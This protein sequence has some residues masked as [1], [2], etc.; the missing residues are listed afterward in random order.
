MRARMC[1]RTVWESWRVRQVAVRRVRLMQHRS[2]RVRPKAHQHSVVRLIAQVSKGQVGRP[3]FGASVQHLEHGARKQCALGVR[4]T[5][6]DLADRT[7]A[8]QERSSRRLI[9]SEVL[10]DR[11]S[12]RLIQVAGHSDERSR[13]RL[14]E[15]TVEDHGSALLR[16]PDSEGP[17]KVRGLNACFRLHASVTPTHEQREV[18]L[19]VNVAMANII[20]KHI[21]NRATGIP[22]LAQQEVERFAH[23]RELVA[24]P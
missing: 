3:T 10:R 7:R 4:R 22:P 20:H 14:G 9:V 24:G 8:E 5:H 19:I 16:R 1:G 23:P 18:T 2:R 17:G 12:H 15:A 13:G 6:R 11:G 21:G